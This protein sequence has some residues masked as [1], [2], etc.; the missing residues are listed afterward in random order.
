MVGK[1]SG[2]RPNTETEA[3]TPFI[4]GSGGNAE[5][6]IAALSLSAIL[7]LLVK[8][9]SSRILLTFIGFYTLFKKIYITGI[10]WKFL[11]KN[12]DSY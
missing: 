3:E 6:I 8:S 4:P 12:S 7:T 5:T 10:F 1:I 11:Y 2:L 9:N